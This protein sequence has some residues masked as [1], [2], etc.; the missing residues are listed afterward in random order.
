MPTRYWLIDPAL[1]SAVGRLEAEG[2]VR[3]A[4]AEVDPGRAGRGPSSATRPSATP[5]C[6]PA[7][8]DPAPAGASGGTRLG[9]KCLHAHY[10]WFLAGGDDPVGAWVQVA[11]TWSSY[12]E[13]RTAG[14]GHRRRHQL[15]APPGG[16]GRPDRR[17]GG[18]APGTGL[19]TLDRRMTITR[20]GQ[21]VDATGRLDPAAI[22][23]TVAVLAEYRRVIDDLGARAGAHDRH[24]G[25]PRRRQPR[26]L[27]RP[28]PRR[29]WASPPSC[30]RAPRRPTCPS[31][32]P[33]PTSI[34]PRARSWSSTWA[35]ARPSSPTASTAVR[36]GPVHR[37]GL[38]PLH[39][40][41]PR[42]RPAPTRGAGG[43]AVGGRGLRR[44]R[45]PGHPRVGRGPHLRGPGRHRHHRGG[46][47]DRAGHLRPRRHPPLRA[48][49]GGGRGRVPHPGHRDPGRSASPIRGWRR[50]GPTSSWAAC[51]C[52][53]PSCA[54]SG[55]TPAW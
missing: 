25:R 51:A 52:W 19:V 4:E 22:D 38:R 3:R 39:R 13:R 12:R 20:L 1:R 34:R 26:R 33:P 27:L 43:R 50:P 21:G 45:P 47:G 5:R 16:R 55:S 37:D 15:G 41:V 49:Q 53:S 29:R 24:L 32:A 8:R 42:A 40:E 18:A 54:A 23:R 14:G 48:D 9:V 17:P 11:S 44:R 30:C 36:G 6:P 35:G 10:A 7:T 28:R 46:R 2:G 31:P